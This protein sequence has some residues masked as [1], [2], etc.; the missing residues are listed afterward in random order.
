M[1]GKP[2]QYITGRQEFYGREFRVTPDVLI[3]APGDRASGRS[4]PRRA[5]SPGDIV[6]DVGTGSGAI[7]ITSGARNQHAQFSPPIFRRRPLRIASE[8]AQQALSACQFS[9][10][11]SCRLLRAIAA[12]TL[13]VSN[14]PYV[15]QT[16]QPSAPARS[17]RLRAASRP[18]RRTH[19][20]RNL[21]APDRRSA[22]RV[23]RP[24]GWLLLE[25]GYNSLEPV[26]GCSDRDWSEIDRPGR[27]GR[28]AARAAS[29]P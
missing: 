10:L 25:L 11:R 13:L 2:T 1:K 24:G 6:L 26:R 17:P 12:S 22:A 28:P 4:G 3:P 15:P 14:P 7:A 29:S 20:P 8:N 9:R 19:R 18:V 16:D 23:L 21:R 27:S 5:S